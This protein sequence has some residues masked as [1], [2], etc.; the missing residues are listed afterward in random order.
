M[1]TPGILLFILL[2]SAF[3]AFSQEVKQ[4]TIREK[5]ARVAVEHTKPFS[6]DYFNQK[7]NQHLVMIAAITEGKISR[8]QPVLELRP[9]KIEKVYTSGNFRVAWFNNEGKM[10][11][12]YNRPDPNIVR[13][14]EKPGIK[15]IEKGKFEVR[16]PGDPQIATVTLSR[17][18]KEIFRWNV[19]EQ[20][21]RLTNR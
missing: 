17:D 3:T 15:K 14:W 12:S 6:I 9:G 7:K 20:V 19:A 21:K 16:I 18:E 5:K 4:E 10:L 11:G 1:K 8:E 13:T 2:L